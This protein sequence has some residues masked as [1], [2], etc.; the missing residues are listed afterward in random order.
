MLDYMDSDMIGMCHLNRECKMNNSLTAF[1][2]WLLNPGV[3]CIY[4][5][6]LKCCLCPSIFLTLQ[7]QPSSWAKARQ[8]KRTYAT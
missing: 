8:P 1:E 6:L 3:P 2:E 4:I 7:W 5:K